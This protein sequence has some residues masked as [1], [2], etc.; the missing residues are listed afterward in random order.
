MVSQENHDVWYVICGVLFVLLAVYTLQIIEDVLKVYLLDTHN[1]IL[2]DDFTFT[3]EWNSELLHEAGLSDDLLP[4]VVDSGQEAGKLKD[5]WYGIPANT[6]VI[7]SLG[8]QVLL[9]LYVL[10]VMN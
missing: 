8:K 10:I 4:T 9:F 1:F 6:P 7:A 5:S 3:Q 2:K